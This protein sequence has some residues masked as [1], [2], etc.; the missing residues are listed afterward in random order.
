MGLDS[1]ELVMNVEKHFGISIPDREAEQIL[2]VADF[3][4]C[5]CRHVAINSGSRCRSQYL[6]YVLRDY[7]NQEH[8]VPKQEIT[9]ST[10]LNELFPFETREVRWNRFSANL[11]IELPDLSAKDVSN[12]TKGK[13]LFDFIFKKNEIVNDRTLRDLVGWILSLN[14]EQ[15]IDINYL[16]DKTEVL[17]IIIGII[18]DTNGIPVEEIESH[19]RITYDLG[20]D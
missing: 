11:G 9:P 1:V 13:L 5:V 14:H 16:F 17:R 7:F 3:S 19:H 15:L 6:F 2:T 18:S 8:N 20:I 10:K 12:P 4:D